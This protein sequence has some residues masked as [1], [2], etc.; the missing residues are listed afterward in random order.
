MNWAVASSRLLY[1]SIRI[2]D[3]E[4]RFIKPQTPHSPSSQLQ[5][6]EEELKYLQFLQEVTNDILIR[7][8]YHKEALDVLLRMHI[9]SRRHDLD[10][11]KMRKLFQDLKEEL[12]SSTN[13]PDPSISYNGIIAQ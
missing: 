2:T 10:E 3:H 7:S 13:Q 11:V 5:E 4:L 6:K 9:R 1:K 12:N 8:C